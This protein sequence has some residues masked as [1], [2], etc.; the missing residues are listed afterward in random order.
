MEQLTA[1]GTGYAVAT[2]CYTT[3]F[4]ISDG[5]EHFMIDT[6]GGSGVLTNL[7]K[8][9]ISVNQVHHIFLS[10]CHTDHVLGAVWMLRMIGH[11]MQRGSYQGTLHLYC[12]Q[13]IA[14]GLW[15][16]CQFM[17]PGRLLPLFGERILF[18]CLAD[19]I[20]FDILGRRT[21]FFDTCSKKT[22]QFGVQLQLLNGKSFTYLGDEPYREDCAAYAAGVDY[23]MHEAMC[24]T[25][26]EE[27][28]HPHPIQHSTVKDAAQCA[29]A[30]Q[31]KNLIMHHTEDEHLAQRKTTYAA[32][33]RQYFDGGVYVPDDL[34][35]ITL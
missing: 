21:V 4:T 3:C 12:H 20:T 16:M 33:A 28:Y 30:L 32:E 14:D 5:Q 27:Q 24:L 7:E 6:G 23:L 1:L 15:Q 22:K 8:L 26:Q 9:G 13:D 17:L 25:S 11:S 31:A 29:A 35:V 10:H 19:G 18:H 2:K 34:E